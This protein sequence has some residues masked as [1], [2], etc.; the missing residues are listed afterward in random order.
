MQIAKFH[1]IEETIK[2]IDSYLVKFPFGY[3]DE[4]IIGVRESIL[5]GELWPVG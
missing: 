3:D 4:A 2:T 5:K 1:S